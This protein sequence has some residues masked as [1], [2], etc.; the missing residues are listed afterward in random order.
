MY[1][2]A[3]RS[4]EAKSGVVTG[5]VFSMPVGRAVPKQIGPGRP[6]CFAVFGPP[7]SGKS[8]AVNQIAAEVLRRSE[9][10]VSTV[11]RRVALWTRTINLTQVTNVADLSNTVAEC[12]AIAEERHEV[13]LLFF[14]EFDANRGSAA[15]G[16]LSWFLAPMRLRGSGSGLPFRDPL[17]R[18]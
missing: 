13:P 12:L 2:F 9:K 11:A 15:Y 10:S 16:W 8:F 6:L 18:P 3:L 1:A 17:P 7:G 14:D 5:V 4:G